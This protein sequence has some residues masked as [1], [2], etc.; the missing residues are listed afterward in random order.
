MDLRELPDST[1]V[2]RHPWEVIRARFFSG[3]V[4]AERPSG[5]CVLDVGAGDGYLARELLGRLPPES[6]VHCVDAFYTEASL[7]RA[8]AGAP[9]A[10]RF[11]AERPPGPFDLVLLLDVVEH[12]VDDGGFLR[13]IVREIRPG[14]RVLVS[15]P[16]WMALYSRHD[17]A[18]GHYRRYRPAELRALVEGCGLVIERAGGLFHGLLL[19]RV[20]AKLGE[21]ARGVRSRPASDAVPRQAETGLRRWRGGPF[22]TGAACAALAVDTWL[23]SA[24]ARARL[25]VP[26]LSAWALA[27]KP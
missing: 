5:L 6:E 15:V 14:G 22:V 8:W 11:H 25:G 27:R 10:L 24:S 13:E 12:V 16:A 4:A 1:K 23:S 2:S 19:P 17:R 20:L 7:R 18:L 26:G 21:R 3:L 9:A